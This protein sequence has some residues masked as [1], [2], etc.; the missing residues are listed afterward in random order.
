MIEISNFVIEF[1]DESKLADTSL[2]SRPCFIDEFNK[3]I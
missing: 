3:T 2:N 1:N